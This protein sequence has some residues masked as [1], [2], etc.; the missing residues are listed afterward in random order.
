MTYGDQ[1]EEVAW[2]VREGRFIAKREQDAVEEQTQWRTEVGG[3]PWGFEQVDGCVVGSVFVQPEH[4]GQ[5]RERRQAQH[6]DF[7]S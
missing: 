3:F 5:A 6:L 1:G 2:E 4:G 7:D